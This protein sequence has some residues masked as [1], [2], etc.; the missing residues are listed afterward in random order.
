MLP[1]ALALSLD[2]TALR[3]LKSD[4]ARVTDADLERQTPCRGWTVADLLAHMNSEHAAICGA[5]S[6]RS[7][8]PRSEFATIADHWIG[9]FEPLAGQ[10]VMVPGMQAELPSEVVLATHFADMVIHRWD[11]AAALGIPCEAE[12]QELQYVEM[13]AAVVTAPASRLVG[14]Q[15]AYAPAL[16]EDPTA[17]RL[18]ALVRRYGRDHKA[19]AR[20]T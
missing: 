2:R 3:H 5:F 12:P 10:K 8:D 11:L 17:S 15:G 1:F 7:K 13:V 9:F 16:A 6:D 4:V 19:A 20:K 14:P 18:D